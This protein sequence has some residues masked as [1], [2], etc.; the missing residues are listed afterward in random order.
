MIAYVDFASYIQTVSG[1]KRCKMYKLCKG[2]RIRV[3]YMMNHSLE[4]KEIFVKD[5]PLRPLLIFIILI[6][7]VVHFKPL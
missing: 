6:L 1:H 7:L 4:G 3:Y 5:T 2:T